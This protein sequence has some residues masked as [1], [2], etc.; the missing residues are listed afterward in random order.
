MRR[1]EQKLLPIARKWSGNIPVW[2]A[3]AV[4]VDDSALRHWAKDNQ[5]VRNT[6]YGIYTWFNDDPEIDWGYS[7]VARYVGQAGPD[8][9]LW[10]P[11]A[12]EL[13]EIGDAMPTEYSIA[14]PKR[15]RK[16]PGVRWITKPVSEHTDLTEYKGIPVQSVEDALVDSM[17]LMERDKQLTALE[18]ALLRF[19]RLQELVKQLEKEYGLEV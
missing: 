2:E 3:R 8:A 13:M 9:Y 4:G 12:L 17:P 1:I 15:R 7:D 18:D 5:D 6:G 19:P 11:S 10:G 16:K 14:V